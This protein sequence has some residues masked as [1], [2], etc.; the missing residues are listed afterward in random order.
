MLTGKAAETLKH[1]KD[2]TESCNEETRGGAI[3][4]I[5]HKL[6]STKQKLA[7]NVSIYLSIYP[8]ILLSIY[9]SMALKSFSWTLAAFSFS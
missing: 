4:E 5:S 9:L 3:F 6:S 1:S 7:A 2:L 8:S